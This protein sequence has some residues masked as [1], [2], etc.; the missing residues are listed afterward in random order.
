MEDKLKELE[1]LIGTDSYNRVLR[2]M[3]FI[4]AKFPDEIDDLWKEE[5][6]LVF[7]QDANQKGYLY[8]FSD[9]VGIK[10]AQGDIY[11]EWFRQIYENG[12]IQ[13]QFNFGN[14]GFPNNN[15]FIIL[16]IFVC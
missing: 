13:E 5:V 3:S 7:E 8:F 14:N 4:G 2:I 12:D 16:V 1:E 6:N 11:Y 9:C 10:V 15:M